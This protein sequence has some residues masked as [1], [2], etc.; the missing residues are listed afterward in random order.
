MAPKPFPKLLALLVVVTMFAL[1]A[2]VASAWA[3]DCPAGVSSTWCSRWESGQCLQWAA[4]CKSTNPSSTAPHFGAIAYGPK[5]TAYGYSYSWDSEAQAESTAMKNCAQHGNDCEVAVW[6]RQQCGA[7]VSDVGTNYY[8][9]LGLTT[10]LA[11]VD[12]KKSCSKQGG[13]IC[14]QQVSQCSR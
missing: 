14:K 3:Q 1:A 13:K 8:W 2:P 11:I 9:G 6:F 5:S 4:I 12:A 7:V 10:T